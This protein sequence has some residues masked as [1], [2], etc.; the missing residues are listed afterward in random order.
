MS[1]SLNIQVVSCASV[2]GKN[3]C[4]Y[5]A[6]RKL[7][8]SVALLGSDK[9]RAEEGVQQMSLCFRCSFPGIFHS[10]AVTEGDP[11]QFVLISP[12]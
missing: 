1:L 8:W 2:K 4:V 3:E 5:K 6:L 11:T 12:S 10:N 9:G 7:R